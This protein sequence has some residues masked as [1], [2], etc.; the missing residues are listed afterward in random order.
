MVK[1]VMCNGYAYWNCQAEH[2]VAGAQACVWTANTLTGNSILNPKSYNPMLNSS[3]ECLLSRRSS[4]SAG[5]LNTT[6][7]P[8]RL[9]SLDKTHRAIVTSI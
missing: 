4:R 1:T 8:M 9:H 7:L 3:S 6:Q 2:K 5:L